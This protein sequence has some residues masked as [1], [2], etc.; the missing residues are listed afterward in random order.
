MALI[1][2]E[3]RSGEDM[4]CSSPDL[5]ETYGPAQGTDP[6]LMNVIGESDLNCH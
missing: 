1:L 5:I 2:E 3:Y 6:S 4:N